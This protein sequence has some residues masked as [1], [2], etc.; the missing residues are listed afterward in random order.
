[1]Y[2]WDILSPNPL[3]CILEGL[4]DQWRGNYRKQSS[5]VV[6]LPVV[7]LTIPGHDKIPIDH[8]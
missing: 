6:V 8:W 3:S 5:A 4:C 1:M 7:L 2:I